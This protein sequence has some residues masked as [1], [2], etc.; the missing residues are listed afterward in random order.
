METVILHVS[1][2]NLSETLLVL[3]NHIPEKFQPVI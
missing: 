2:S 1:V 3:A